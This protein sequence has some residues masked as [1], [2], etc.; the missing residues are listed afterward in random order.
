M[1][2]NMMSNSV[3]MTDEELDA[4]EAKLQ[5]R[6]NQMTIRD[7]LG[8]IA[9][10]TADVLLGDVADMIVGEAICDEVVQDAFN[11]IDGETFTEAFI[12]AITMM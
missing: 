1:E 12:K 3:G 10:A 8:D 6:Y 2:E 7:M 4:L 9:K 5:N 11:N